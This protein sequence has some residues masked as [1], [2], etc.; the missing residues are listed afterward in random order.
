[1]RPGRQVAS[2]AISLT[3]ARHSTERVL[4]AWGGGGAGTV[5]H[6]KQRMGA[7]LQEFVITKDLSEAAA[8]LHNLKVPHFHHEF[9]KKAVTA[10]VENP[11]HADAILHLLSELAS[12]GLVTENQAQIGEG[13]ALSS[14]L[15]SSSHGRLVRTVKRV[16]FD[17]LRLLWPTAVR[18]GSGRSAFQGNPRRSASETS[19]TPY[20]CKH[21]LMLI[22]VLWSGTAGFKRM[23]EIIEDLEL[24]VPGAQ[25][26]LTGLEEEAVKLGLYTVVE[27]DIL[28]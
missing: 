10:A 7:I 24:D 3:Q 4:M 16:A 14:R 12:M 5:A 25:A 9:V 21:A 23:H 27:P 19:C 13:L 11:E 8:C 17:P 28:I 1:M 22:A 20:V 6:S 26:R 15:R 2:A 18:V